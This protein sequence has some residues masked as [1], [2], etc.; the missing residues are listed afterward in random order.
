MNLKCAGAQH[1]KQPYGKFYIAISLLLELIIY[2]T[3]FRYNTVLA[4]TTEVE[5]K[6][7]SVELSTLEEDLHEAETTVKWD[8]TG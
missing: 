4:T 6:L 1:I 3:C 2:L 8:Q 5:R 7:L